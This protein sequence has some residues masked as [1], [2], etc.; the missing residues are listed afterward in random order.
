[1]AAARVVHKTIDTEDSARVPPHNH[2]ASAAVPAWASVCSWVIGMRTGHNLLQRKAL[3][4]ATRFT[5][6]E[7][8]VDCCN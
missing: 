2:V 6:A 5:V 1:M 8:W 7:Q 4:Q 3:K